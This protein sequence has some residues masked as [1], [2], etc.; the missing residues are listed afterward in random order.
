[1]E[2]Y[3]NEATFK[4]N[5]LPQQ[6]KIQAPEAQTQGSDDNLHHQIAGLI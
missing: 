2:L 4:G 3:P 1:M 6:H 5:H